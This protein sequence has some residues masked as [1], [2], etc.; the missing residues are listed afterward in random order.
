M[1]GILP[2][3]LTCFLLIAGVTSIPLPGGPPV[4]MDYLAFDAAN[5][6]VW[7]PAGNTGNV[8]VVDAAT[9]TVTAIGGFATA[10]SPRPDRPKMGPSSATVGDGVVWIGNRGDDG[11]CAFD[12]R[13]LAKRACVKLPAMPDGVQYVAATRELWV[14]TPKDQ[15]LTIVDVKGEHPS[16]KGSIKLAG[17]PE[18]Y[19]LD[20]QRGVFYTNLEDKDQ[21]VAIEVRSRKIVSTWPSGCGGDGPRGLALDGARRLLFVACTD[22]AVTLDLAQGG[23]VVG[24]L[25][26]GKGVDNLDYHAGRRLLYVA[27][28][29]DGV[30][31]IAV[32]A[33][34][35]AL[36][37]VATAPTA[38]GARNAVVTDDGTAYVADSPGGRL[39]VVKPPSR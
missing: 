11:V 18:G 21:T 9:G 34:G 19:A 22:G 29:E 12:A 32:V 1:K 35:G 26:T 38:K 4:G 14:T 15:T 25:K 10:A 7:A 3:M 39:I 37:A 27:S 5:H 8:D 13:T 33:D 2:R 23:R 28:R 30:L 16:V 31:T 24:R 36:K 17:D 20:G 6:R